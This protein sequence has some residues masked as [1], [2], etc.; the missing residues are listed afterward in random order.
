MKDVIRLSG[1]SF[2]GYHGAT[3]AEKET[4]RVFEVDCE[5][6][7]DLAEAG[8]TDQ[9]ADTIDYRQAYD[10]IKETVEGHAFSLLEGLADHL[11]ASIL[12]RF[13][14]Y[15]VTLRVRKMNPPIP[16]Q[17]KSIEVELTRFQ[18]D[19]SKLVDNQ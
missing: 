11:A 4:G 18:K 6:E 7:V 12:D 2:Y 10:V 15:R 5:L 16:G 1:L 9:L 17:I 8:R 14:V 3:A 19:T 13:P